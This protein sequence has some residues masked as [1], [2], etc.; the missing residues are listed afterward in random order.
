MFEAEAE[1]GMAATTSVQEGIDAIQALVDRDT[2]R[3]GSNAYEV[4]TA[5]QHEPTPGSPSRH[6]T[7]E[8]LRRYIIWREILAPPLAERRPGALI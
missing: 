4:Q 3:H 5:K 7:R 6:P 2:D 8:E 1:G